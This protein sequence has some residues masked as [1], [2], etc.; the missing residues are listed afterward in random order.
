MAKL[1]IQR[2]DATFQWVRNQYNAI[3][4]SINLQTEFWWTTP[5]DPSSSSTKRKDPRGLDNHLRSFCQRS[6]ALCYRAIAP[7]PCNGPA[8]APSPAC[9]GMHINPFE[10][11]RGILPGH[12]E[13]IAGQS[14][15]IYPW[16]FWANIHPPSQFYGTTELMHAK[17]FRCSANYFPFS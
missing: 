15:C 2:L 10:W 17:V 12:L 7:E 11:V 5:N 6:A 13:H 9:D 14:I 16:L 1:R 3:E 8:P 4:Q